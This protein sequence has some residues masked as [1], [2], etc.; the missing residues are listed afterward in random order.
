MTKLISRN[1]RQKGMSIT[2][3]SIRNSRRYLRTSATDGLSGVPKLMIKT[4][5]LDL[6]MVRY[7]K[8][9]RSDRYHIFVILSMV[10]RMGVGH[11]VFFYLS[12]IILTCPLSVTWS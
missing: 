3:A 11:L 4:P 9:F 8:I 12:S 7:Y 6:A 1:L 5:V 2:R 10:W